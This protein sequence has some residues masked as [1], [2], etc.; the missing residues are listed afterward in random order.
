M[1]ARLLP[2]LRGVNLG[3]RNTGHRRS[4]TTKIHVLNLFLI[5]LVFLWGVKSRH[6]KHSLLTII[7]LYLGMEK[8]R[9]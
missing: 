9:A 7:S 6:P 8:A 5:E 1:I 2:G 4:L 3:G